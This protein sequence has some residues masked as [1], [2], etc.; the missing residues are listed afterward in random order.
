MVW[1]SENL[2]RDEEIQEIVDEEETDNDTEDVDKDPTVADMSAQGTAP[3]STNHH[4]TVP[5][6]NGK[7]DVRKTSFNVV[8]GHNWIGHLPTIY[9]IKAYGNLSNTWALV[10]IL[11]S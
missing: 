11:H 9:K 4:P 7:F 6:R 1:F 8:E 3:Q 5:I 10:N 2:S